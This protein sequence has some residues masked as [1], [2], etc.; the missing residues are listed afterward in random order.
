MTCAN[1]G[2]VTHASTPPRS[3]EAQAFFELV[4]TPRRRDAPRIADEL[5]D[6]EHHRVP[7]VHGA[8]A[9]W[10]LGTGPAV[11]LVHG[12]DDDHLL[13][14]PMTEAFARRGRAVVVFDLPAHGLSEGRRCL[15]WEGTDAMLAVADEMGPVSGA[16]GHSVGAAVVAGALV[17]GLELPACVFIAPPMRTGD[18]W[19]RIAERR[20]VPEHVAAEARSA[21]EQ[22]LGPA[23]AAFRLRRE[24]Q[25]LDTRLLLAGSTDDERTPARDLREAAAAAPGAELLL[26]D[27]AGHRDT[28]RHP[29]VIARTVEFLDGSSAEPD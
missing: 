1:I 18:R 29:E 19:R 6:A 26:V 7:T 17:E 21:Y 9:A 16:V 14:T 11:L 15:G 24:L 25:Q 22:W 4:T 2:S 12:R 27:G 20:G 8:V 13:W 10:R 23:R 28:A 3:P 5:R